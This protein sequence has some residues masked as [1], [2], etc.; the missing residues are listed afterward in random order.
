MSTSEIR[1]LRDGEVD[2]LPRTTASAV[3][4]ADGSTVQQK[5][6]DLSANSGSSGKRTTR[7]TI[8]TSTNGWTEDD[9]DYLCD[10]TDDQVEI[11]NAIIDL[12]ATG[13]EIKILDGTYNIT[14]KIKTVKDNIK[15]SGN[16]ATT[17][18]KRM[19]ENKNNTLEGVITVINNQCNIENLQFDGNRTQFSSNYNCSILLLSDKN[20]I[21]GNICNNSQYGIYLDSKDDNV[22]TGNNCHDN[23]KNGIHLNTGF[24]NI[25][26]GNICYRNSGNGV[27]L[28][29]NNTS[30]NTI[31]GNNCSDNNNSNIYLSGG[32][33]NTITGNTCNGNN[34]SVFG[35]YL[36]Y[37][38]HNTITGNTCNDNGSTGIYVISSNSNTITGNT[39]N[40]NA[41]AGIYIDHSNNNTFIGNTCILGA[42]VTYTSEQY[43]IC[44]SN[45]GNNYNLITNNN[46]MGKD[47][48]NG[49]TT[50][51]NS[52]YG[53]KWNDTIDVPKVTY[54]TTDL[55]AGTSALPTGQIYLVY[56]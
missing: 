9:C 30:R 49:S 46:I 26:T 13:G 43:T 27:Y 25:I 15:I 7:F 44:L 31:I 17:I 1:T 36:S 37:T 41:H 48:T 32:N 34:N 42:G 52:I 28:K 12:P 50:G 53:N 56:E 38:Y 10:G 51:N 18:L 39:C 16:G 5:I 54:G 20:T 29:L 11:N 55:T 45:G 2:V 22:I 24:N 35:I 19:W 47:V 8:G 33:G 40:N 4:T 3:Q 6:N 14:G 21:T 23:A